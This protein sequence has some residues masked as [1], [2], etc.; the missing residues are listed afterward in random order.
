MAPFM[1]YNLGHFTV[2]LDAAVDH[3][4]LDPPAISADAY[5]S[6]A[7]IH[8]HSDFWQDPRTAELSEYLIEMPLPI[9]NASTEHLL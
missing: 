7:P 9:S 2:S 6:P 4:S 3:L 1:F 8:R 5:P